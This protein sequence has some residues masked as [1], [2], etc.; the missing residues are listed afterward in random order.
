MYF[1]PTRNVCGKKQHFSPLYTYQKFPRSGKDLERGQ[2]HSLTVHQT[3]NTRNTRTVF[4]SKYL[5]NVHLCVHNIRL[6]LLENNLAVLHAVLII[7]LCV[8]LG[9]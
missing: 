3:F 6:V 7:I 2:V 9:Q 4:A 1:W 5:L 8:Q